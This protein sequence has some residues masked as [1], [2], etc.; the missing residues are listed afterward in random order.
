M[1]VERRA[2][3]TGGLI[4]LSATVA[5]LTCQSG[6]KNCQQQTYTLTAACRTD[7]FNLGVAGCWACCGV[8]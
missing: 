8:G 4:R 2:S 3:P 7:S 5:D 6:G 1:N